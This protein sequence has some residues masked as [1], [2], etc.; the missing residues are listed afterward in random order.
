MTTLRRDPMSINDGSDE[1][2][3]KLL[4]EGGEKT[5]NS[6]TANAIKP[7]TKSVKFTQIFR[8]MDKLDQ[9]LLT[10]SLLSAAANGAAF[11]SFTFIFAGMLNALYGTDVIHQVR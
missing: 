10:A 1:L 2:G 11:P 5:G 7:P 6:D 8:F 3:A 4:P 9:F